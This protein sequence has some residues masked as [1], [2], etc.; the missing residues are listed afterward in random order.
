MPSFMHDK[1]PSETIPL[2]IRLISFCTVNG[3]RTGRERVQFGT[4][5]HSMLGPSWVSLTSKKNKDEFSCNRLVKL[6]SAKLGYILYKKPLNI[7]IILFS[8]SY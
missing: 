3:R 2:F 1:I 7:R 4:Q 6:S 8:G 5:T